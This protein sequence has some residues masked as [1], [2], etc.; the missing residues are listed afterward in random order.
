MEG[1][2]AEVGRIPGVEGMRGV[3]VV[4]VILFHCFV[5]RPEDPWIVAIGGSVLEP[6]VA[7]G[8]LG[9]DLFFII[10][11]FLLAMPWF[12]HA[13]AGRE[14]PSFR[15]FYARRFWRI[16]PAYYVQLA[17][18]FLVALP[19]VRGT[20]YWRSDL[21]VYLYNIGAHALF[22]HNT[23][24]LSS[25]S[26]GINGALWTLAVEMQFYL[27]LPLLMP[28]FVRW[29]ASMLAACLAIAASWRIESHL[30]LDGLVHAELA[31]GRVW[32]WQEDV[33]RYLV[34]HQLPSYLFHF[35][36]GIALGRVWIR[37]RSRKLP[38]WAIDIVG[39]AGAVLLYWILAVNGSML[40]S[41]SWML[42]PPA[43]GAMLYWSASRTGPWISALLG[44]GPL[45]ATGR[46]SYSAYLYH[47]PLL[48]LANQYLAGVAAWMVI[49]LYVAAT[50]AVA[51]V[52][53]RY[54]EQR[55]LRGLR[56]GTRT[57]RERRPDGQ[58]LQRGHAPEHR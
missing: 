40:G 24:P 55:F 48:I 6:F 47:L 25:G 13:D 34:E 57:D 38:A 53:W 36:L 35:A 10:S 8:Y 37:N 17:F 45:A 27:L 20:T 15:T 26:M 56:A 43:L 4:W 7:N 32:S 44:R 5:L 11:G 52:S 18:L 19:L 14:A 23:T 29:P 30:G 31:F 3:A 21:W 51:W 16:A 39:V 2:R 9:V 22:M 58:D 41:M 42:A 49:P 1:V 12:L 54:V 46:I 33:V 28:L 50:L